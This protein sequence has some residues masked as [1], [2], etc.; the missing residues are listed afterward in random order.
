MVQDSERSTRPQAGKGTRLATLVAILIAAV[1]MASAGV[2]WR[3]AIAESRATTSEREGMIAAVKREAAMAAD[4][5]TLLWEA[6]YAADHALYLARLSVLEGDED[7]G[8]DAEAEGLA[9][10]VDSLAG[11]TPLS[12][13]ESYRTSDGGF[14]LD[15]RLDDLRGLNPD[16]Q[17]VEPGKYFSEADRYHLESRLLLSAVVVFAISLFFLTLAE[18]TPHRARY[19]LAAA[20]GLIFLGGL[21]GVIAA[22]LYCV[23]AFAPVG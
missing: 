10:I 16:L 12:T 4:V 7:V 2:V 11:F 17:D 9:V 1:S 13:D 8:A 5:S 15:A 20:G 23:L 19:V 14:D 6:R 3:A 21:A 22:E 18:I